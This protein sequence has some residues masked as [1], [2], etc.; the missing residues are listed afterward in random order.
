VALF[1]TFPACVPSVY[2]SRNA[3]LARYAEVADAASPH[4][5][6]AEGLVVLA[7]WRGKN[8]Q[9]LAVPRGEG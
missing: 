6:V 7:T 9:D 5:G 1:T 2:L 3:I 4:R 8:E